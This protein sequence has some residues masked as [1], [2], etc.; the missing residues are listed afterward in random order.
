MVVWS[1]IQG[2]MV[3][4]KR[5]CVYLLSNTVIL[6]LPSYPGPPDLMKPSKRREDSNITTKSWLSVADRQRP[7]PSSIMFRDEDALCFEIGW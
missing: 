4:E 5:Q 1:A 2:N 7:N 3:L 6:G